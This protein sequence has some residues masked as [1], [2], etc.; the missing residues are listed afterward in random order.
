MVHMFVFDGV[1]RGNYFGGE[2]IIGRAE[3]E[4]RVGKFKNGKSTVKD[5]IT[6][7]VIKGGSDRMVDWV[8]R[9]CNMALESDVV[10]EH[11]RS[12]V[13]VPLYKGKGV[14]V[15]IGEED[16]ECELYIELIQDLNIWHVFW[17]KQ[18]PIG[19]N[20]VGRWG[21]GGGWEGPLIT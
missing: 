3:V 5:D 21:V 4:V 10:P 7:E 13:I 18:G 6:G 1:Q 11:W 8:W 20:L 14:M 16:L 2:P 9:L 17:M 15:L 12:A 19:W